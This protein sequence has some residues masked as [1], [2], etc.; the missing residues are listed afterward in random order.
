MKSVVVFYKMRSILETLYPDVSHILDGKGQGKW[1]VLL[2]T[3]SKW[4]FR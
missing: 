3:L 4:F 1:D 2:F